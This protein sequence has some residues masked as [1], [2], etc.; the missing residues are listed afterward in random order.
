MN[1]LPLYIIYKQQW[2]ST[3]ESPN[4]SSKTN[5]TWPHS[6]SS[7]MMKSKWTTKPSKSKGKIINKSLPRSILISKGP[8]TRSKNN[9]IESYKKITSMKLIIHLKEKNIHKSMR[10]IC[11]TKKWKNMM[12]IWTNTRIWM[13]ENI[14]RNSQKKMKN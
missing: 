10:N 6:W 4:L 11:Q 5:P 8:S 2:P 9:I 12:T 13:K 7:S 14:Q 3:T 1:N